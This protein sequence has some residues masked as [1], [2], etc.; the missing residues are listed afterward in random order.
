MLLLVIPS[1]LH[2]QLERLGED[3]RRHDREVSKFEDSIGRLFTCVDR[4]RTKVRWVPCTCPAA[5]CREASWARLATSRLTFTGRA[6]G[7]QA[8]YTDTECFAA[9]TS[10]Q[11]SESACWGSCLSQV[12]LLSDMLP[13]RAHAAIYGPARLPCLCS[14]ALEAD[15][16]AGTSSRPPIE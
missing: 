4:A 6:P 14:V 3:A 13:G 1:S 11:G 8:A 9:C 16:G 10:K 12:R 2:L 15:A 7:T 5:N